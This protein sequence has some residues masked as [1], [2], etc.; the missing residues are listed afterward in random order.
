MF[1][2]LALEPM[3][4]ILTQAVTSRMPDPIGMKTAPLESGANR[5]A[6]FEARLTGIALI[7]TATV[8]FSFLDTSAKYLV[9]VAHLPLLQIVWVRFIV[10][11]AFIIAAVGPTR[12][13]SSL[14]SR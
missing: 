13:M 5:R 3:P 8:L 1:A 2:T 11:A 9:T 6:L 10:N 7:C 14:K 4:N 12:A